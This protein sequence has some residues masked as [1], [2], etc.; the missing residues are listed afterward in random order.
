MRRTER[1]G[2]GINFCLVE[3]AVIQI[4]YL[5]FGFQEAQKASTNGINNW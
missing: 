5:S 2:L 4:D 1:R 3:S